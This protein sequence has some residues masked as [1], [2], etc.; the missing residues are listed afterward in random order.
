[1]NRIIYSPDR[2]SRSPRP[3]ERRRAPRV[4]QGGPGRE[5]DVQHCERDEDDR[6]DGEQLLVA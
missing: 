4:E 5:E 1:V 6:D 3:H 2:S